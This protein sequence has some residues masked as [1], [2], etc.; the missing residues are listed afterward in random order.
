MASPLHKNDNILTYYNQIKQ[1]I[2][3]NIDMNSQKVIGQTKLA[4]IL[5]NEINEEIPES[6]FL[7]LNSENIYINNTKTS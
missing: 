1:R 2:D 5:N 6:L 3:L 7:Y 4:F